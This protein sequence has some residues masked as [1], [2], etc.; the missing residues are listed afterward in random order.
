MKTSGIRQLLRFGFITGSILTLVG[1]ATP[2]PKDY[3]A[4]KAANPKSIVV[5]PPINKTPEINATVGFY[6]NT[7]RPI[8]E[9][10]FYVFP[11]SLVFET[12]KGNGVSIPDEIHNVELRKIRE[13]FGADAAMYIVIKEYGTK[14]QVFSS[15]SIVTADSKLID[16][17]TGTTLWEGTA[18]ASSS[19]GQDNSQA[20]LAG[21]LIK[22]IVSQVVGTVTDQSFQISKR[23]SERLLSAD[24]IN[25]ILYG[26]YHSK[27]RQDKR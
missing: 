9:S 13:I 10:G 19:E 16:L 2:K 23:T 17:R 18:T 24:A 26:P 11:A 1:C 6:S 5:L 8:G 7:H 20:G 21:L 25:G 22:A 14:F 4:F 15:A 27:Y 3:S 12:F